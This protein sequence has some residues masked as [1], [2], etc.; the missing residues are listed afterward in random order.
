MPEDNQTK[1][2]KE[3]AKEKL[4]KKREYLVKVGLELQ[5][6]TALDPRYYNGRN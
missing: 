4:R 5:K 3:R 6:G 2:T 1:T